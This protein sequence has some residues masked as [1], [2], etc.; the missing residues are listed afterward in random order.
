MG[1]GVR[2]TKIIIMTSKSL[3]IRFL[4]VALTTLSST[5][6]VD[7]LED[8]NHASHPGHGHPFGS[9][10]PFMPIDEAKEM[11]T[12]QFFDKYVKVKRA[13][14]IRGMARK[15]P[16]F[17]HW[18]T[19][20]YLKEAA[21]AHDNLKLLVETQK[22]ESRDQDIISLSLDEFI[23]EYLKKEI[24]I[25]DEVPFYLKHDLL[26]PQPLQ[27]GQAPET[28]ERTVLINH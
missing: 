9:S 26:L 19:D 14:V 5:A 25:V 18:S 6:F 20:E 27:C 15:F 4:L 3:L 1:G 16:A 11:P 13:L 23:D 21:R 10:G 28:L 17:K 2:E 8:D 7:C 12:R 24:Y 22:K